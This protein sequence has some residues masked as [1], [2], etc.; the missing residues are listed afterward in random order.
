FLDGEDGRRS[1]PSLDQVAAVLPQILQFY[2]QPDAPFCVAGLHAMGQRC[3]VILVLDFLEIQFRP[4]VAQF[5]K[6]LASR[7]WAAVASPLAIGFSHAYWRTVSSSR[8]RAS[9]PCSAYT[10]SDFSTNVVRRS[11]NSHSSVPS[12]AQ[13]ASAAGKVHP[14]AN[15]DSRCSSARSGSERR[16]YLESRVARSVCCRGSAVRLPPL[17]RRNM[18]SSRSFSFSTGSAF[19]RAAASS[20]ASG[21]PSRR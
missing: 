2:D 16:S 14:P 1:L 4:W 15:T 11:N 17:R 20:R 3:T 19:T 13:I 5:R 6:N 7:R 9:A 12:S 10:T 21:M 8:Y 18:S